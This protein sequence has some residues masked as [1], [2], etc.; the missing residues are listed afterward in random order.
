MM[1]GMI[2]RNLRAATPPDAHDY[3]WMHLGDASKYKSALS[4]GNIMVGYV[5]LL[6]RKGRIRWMAHGAP[7]DAEIGHLVG[8]ARDLAKQDTQ[9]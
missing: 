5:Y 1:I 7:S 6:D 3:I 4:L 9:P 8:A 2:T